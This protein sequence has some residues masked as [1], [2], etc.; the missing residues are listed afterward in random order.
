[1]KNAEKS[2]KMLTPKMD[3]CV[4]ELFRNETVLKCFL[5]DILSIEL[6]DIKK[7]KIVNPFLWKRKKADKQGILEIRIELNDGAKIDIE[8][9]VAR[10]ADWDKRSLFY[11]AKMFTEDLIIG[12]DYSKLKKC[13]NISILDYNLL[14]GDDYHTVYRLRDENAKDFTDIMELHIVE[15]RKPLKGIGNVDDWIRFFN[16]ETMEDLNMDAANNMGIREALA[17]LKRMNQSKWVR[18]SHEARLKEIRDKK[19]LLKYAKSEGKKEGII[20]GIIEL[21]KEHGE[22]PVL[23]LEKITKEKDL[24]QLKKWLKVAAKTGSIAEFER[25]M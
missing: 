15:L 7:A 21:L 18:A 2:V 8:M 22:V 17:E 25:K 24:E 23:L 6:K 16:I 5:S 9:Q 3:F 13:I 1:M 19:S 20:E 11:L 12:E 14:E 10:F 4:K